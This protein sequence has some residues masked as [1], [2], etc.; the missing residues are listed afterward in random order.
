MKAKAILPILS[1]QNLMLLDG[2]QLH[3]HLDQ[4]FREIDGHRKALRLREI[5]RKVTQD[6]PILLNSITTSV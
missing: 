1:Y 6:P 3:T 5:H 2:V 4:Q